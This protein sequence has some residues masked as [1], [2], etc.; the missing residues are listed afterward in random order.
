LLGRRCRLQGPNTAA[1]ADLQF[2]EELASRRQR[3]AVLL[4]G[5]EKFNRSGAKDGLAF[6]QQAG[7]LR[8]LDDAEELA[9]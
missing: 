6:L 3:K 9:K 2:K 5:A 7:V 4:A 8:S 1:G